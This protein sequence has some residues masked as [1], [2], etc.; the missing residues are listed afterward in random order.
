MINNTFSNPIR[1]HNYDLFYD[2]RSSRL[3]NGCYWL[4][5]SWRQITSWH[6]MQKSYIK[7]YYPSLKKIQLNQ[8]NQ[9]LGIDHGGLVAID[10]DKDSMI[11]QSSWTKAE[12]SYGL[13]VDYEGKIWLGKSNG[14]FFFENNTLLPAGIDHPA[15]HNR[16]EDVDQLP[17]SSLVLGTKG[18][19]VLIWK[20]NKII[21]ITTDEGLTTNMMEDLHV[22][23]QGI[24]WAGTLNGLNKITFDG[25][26]E[27]RVRAFTTSNG[28]PSNE[29]YQIK[30]HKGQVW[31]CTSGGLVKFNE[32]QENLNSAN[33]ILQEVIVNGH[34]SKDSTL[35]YHHNNLEFRFL[36]VNF[37]MNGKIPYRY[38][39]HQKDN[40]QYTH[41]LSV[42]YPALP[43]GNY[44]FEVQSQNE[45]GYWSNS[46]AYAFSISPPWV[47]YLVVSWCGSF[48]FKFFGIQRL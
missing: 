42:N 16:I 14:L 10:Q 41:N 5:G 37:R 44:R 6:R 23:D 1:P 25:D 39:L 26:G 46:T 8:Q 21:S 2:Y 31:L 20:K 47:G 24:L 22:D 27:A 28:L 36:T 32:P 45:D 19:G 29:I 9:L 12:R 15:F 35:K 48:G 34:F 30:S 13:H 11:L 40:W 38:R 3:W 4:N 33:P 7:R 43:R 18:Y 17:D